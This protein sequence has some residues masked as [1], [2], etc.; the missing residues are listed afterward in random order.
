MHFTERILELFNDSGNVFVVLKKPQVEIPY[1]CIEIENDT[2]APGHKLTIPMNHLVTN[3]KVGL[4]LLKRLK[5][6]ENMKRLLKI[7]THHDIL[8]VVTQTLMQNF[9]I[10]LKF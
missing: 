8:L 5:V 3:K 4:K 10:V 9:E 1:Y 7:S 6:H 2:Y